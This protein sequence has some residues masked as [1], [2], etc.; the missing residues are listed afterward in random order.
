MVTDESYSLGLLRLT[1][2]E[3]EVLL[4]LASGA[5]N[6]EI[7]VRLGIRPVTVESHLTRIYRKLEVRSRLEAIVGAARCGL[8]DALRQRR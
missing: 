5:R 4:Q 8:L 7:A 3:R 1:K 6:D 2:R